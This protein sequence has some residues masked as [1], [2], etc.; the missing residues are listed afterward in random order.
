[1][2]KSS[3]LNTLEIPAVRMCF[4]EC[5]NVVHCTKEQRDGDQENAAA[6]AHSLLKWVHAHP[7]FIS[8]STP[9]S[10]FYCARTHTERAVGENASEWARAERERWRIHP[11]NGLKR[12]HAFFARNI[13]MSGWIHNFGL[14][15]GNTFQCTTMAGVPPPQPP[16][17]LLLGSWSRARS[18]SLPHTRAP[19]FCI[20]TPSSEIDW[21]LHFLRPV[22][23]ALHQL[24]MQNV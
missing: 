4:A 7:Y 11:S 5:V 12:E 13:Y 21:L 9:D 14:K 22:V 16:A 18:P 2:F 17:C 6:A 19:R 10:S 1:M 8:I 15:S 24:G 20:N 23:R 3:K